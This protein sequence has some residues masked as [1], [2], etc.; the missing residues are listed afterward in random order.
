MKKT[1]ENL[2]AAFMGESQARM[3]Y[4]MFS[5]IAK[6]EGYVLISEIFDET[7]NHEREHA[8]WNYK[9]LQDLK[10]EESFEEL[11]VNAVGPTT[12]GITEENLK[13]AIAGEDY[14][15]K[16]MYP[17]FADIA[18]KEG[19]QSIADRF[20]SIARAEKH[21]SERYGKLL[22]L[23]GD[24][25]FFKR[26][27]KVVWVCMECGYEVEMDSLPEKWV[28]PACNHPRSSYRLKCEEF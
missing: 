2:M 18:E 13:S 1:V 28:C 16:E 22:K 6:K 21:H 23:V 19:Y 12:Y 24:D 26:D 8:T 11:K 9:M 14:E 25:V 3:R 4:T 20:R 10:K 7:A 17:G 5:K 27:K 15:W